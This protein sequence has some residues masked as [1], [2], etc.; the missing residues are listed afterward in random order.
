MTYSMQFNLLENTA[1]SNNT[2]RFNVPSPTLGDVVISFGG[3]AVHDPGGTINDDNDPL[4][5]GSDTIAYAPLVGT[6]M[7]TDSGY[8]VMSLIFAAPSGAR[9]VC[10]TWAL[11]SS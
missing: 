11:I 2:V 10:R 3:H 9:V 5:P 1:D 8:Y 4:D 6:Y 7:Y